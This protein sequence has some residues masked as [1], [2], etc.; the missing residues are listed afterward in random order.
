MTILVTG[1]TGFIGQHVVGQ[2]LATDGVR[3]L[4]TARTEPPTGK[5][6]WLSRV[7]F[8]PFDLSTDWGDTDLFAYFGHPDAVIHL[9]WQGLPDYQSLA[10]VETYWLQ[11]YRFLT[12]LISNGLTDLTVT[13]TCLEYG[14][15]SGCL[16]EDLPTQPTTAYGLAKDNLRKALDLFLKN[17]A[18]SFKWLRL[19]Y[20]YG[21]GQNPKSLL[22]QVEA[23]A[24]RHEPV[25]NMSK[26]EQLRD[27]LPMT[28]VAAY[29]AKT[30]LQQNVTGSINCC[31][32]Q[33]IAVRT[34]V[35]RFMQ[36][37]NYAMTLN[38]G[39][40]PYPDYEPL[41]FWGD[42]RKLQNLLSNHD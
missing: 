26:G 22:A 30:A 1:A 17:H 36:E 5:T 33:P 40:Y 15:Q 3:V 18:V 9:A 13:G 21:K 27:Y 10:H 24:R 31:S 29:L 37:N 14:L 28:T 35:E 23:A 6:A 41:A 4:A 32:G 34:L 11:H 16:S 38:L 20:M 25:F 7:P 8:T 39:H 2:L 12:N 42:N 19:F